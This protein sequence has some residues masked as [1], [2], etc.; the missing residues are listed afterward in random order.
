MIPPKCVLCETRHHGHQAH[1]F[2]TNERTTPRAQ[3][4]VA[5]NRVIADAT[6]AGREELRSDG[7]GR[8]DR[9]EPAVAVAGTG[10]GEAGKT[11]NRRARD[12]YN[13]YQREYMRKRRAAA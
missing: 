6:N 3:T 10:S 7:A 12:A 13:A 5:T 9:A 8:V 2:A 11:K 1:V 4:F